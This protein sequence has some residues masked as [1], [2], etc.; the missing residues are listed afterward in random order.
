MNLPICINCSKRISEF[1][2][3]LEHHHEDVDGKDLDYDWARVFCSVCGSEV[4][5][6]ELETASI[7]DL[8]KAIRRLNNET[9]D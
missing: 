6:E 1:N 4:W 2:V 8:D 9:L 5:F 7:N 3:V